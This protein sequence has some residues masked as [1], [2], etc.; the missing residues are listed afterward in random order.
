MLDDRERQIKTDRQRYAQ[1]WQTQLEQLKRDQAEIE[2][3]MKKLMDSTAEQHTRMVTEALDKIKSETKAIK[4]K[5]QRDKAE[6]RRKHEVAKERALQ[7][8]KMTRKEQ[9]KTFKRMEKISLEKLDKW[10][11]DFRAQAKGQIMLLQESHRVQKA[12]LNRKI[13]K[14][15]ER[16]SS[17]EL[18]L[19]DMT[20]L[21]K[22]EERQKIQPRLMR[23]KEAYT[24]L[25]AEESSVDARENDLKLTI[26][27]LTAQRA[28]I[29]ASLDE[30]KQENERIA[31]LHRE[32]TLK[33]EE[34]Q[35]EKAMIL[36]EQE[37]IRSQIDLAEVENKTLEKQVQHLKDENNTIAE[38]K[39]EM[40]AKDLSLAK[41]IEKMHTEMEQKESQIREDIASYET[42]LEKQRTL[43]ESLE[44]KQQEIERRSRDLTLWEAEV[45]QKT[46]T[47]EEFLEVQAQCG[48]RS[49]GPSLQ[50]SPNCSRKGSFNSFGLDAYIRDASTPPVTGIDG[51]L[52]AHHHGGEFYEQTGGAE[53]GEEEEEEE[54][55]RMLTGGGGGAVVRSD[56]LNTASVLNKGGRRGSRQDDEDSH[57]GGGGRETAEAAC[58]KRGHGRGQGAT[59][60]V[61]SGRE[62]G[63]RRESKTVHGRPTTAA[64]NIHHNNHLASSHAPTTASSSSL[65]EK[66]TTKQPPAQMLPPYP[67]VIPTCTS[68][69]H[70]ALPESGLA[71]SSFNQS[72]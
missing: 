39:K 60:R 10:T 4:E 25:K 34:I 47:L 7:E 54:E 45:N 1:K 29:Q 63:T 64:T 35:E 21:H 20:A 5:S 13:A 62:E 65:A 23:A 46:S 49:V 11:N 67:K 22:R 28:D 31:K 38:R 17:A 50:N 8:F 18:R 24:K 36:L 9:D 55:L 12:E 57:P 72:R 71:L 32:G 44:K 53:E 33:I 26:Q 69:Q 37:Q 66:M 43:A 15:K 6:L 48:P 40:E 14:A 42:E 27:R 19:E 58:E 41:R 68:M 61:R 3:D 30:T 16:L 59:G 2:R 51:Q 52:N 56:G 70:L